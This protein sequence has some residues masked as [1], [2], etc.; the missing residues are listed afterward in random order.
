MKGCAEVARPAIPAFEWEKRGR[1]EMEGVQGSFS[2]PGRLLQAK[3]G[4]LVEVAISYLEDLH[5]ACAALAH[6]VAHE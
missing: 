3:A 1:E 5:T 2:S 6:G 4:D